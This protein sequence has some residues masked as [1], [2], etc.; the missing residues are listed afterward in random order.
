MAACPACLDTPGALPPA[1]HPRSY[2][3]RQS[4]WY[5]VLGRLMVFEGHRGMDEFVA[6]FKHRAQRLPQQQAAK[7]LASFR[8]YPLASLDNE[9]RNMGRA[10]RRGLQASPRAAHELGAAAVLQQTRALWVSPPASCPWSAPQGWT[11]AAR[12]LI[13]ACCRRTTA[14]CCCSRCLGSSSWRRRPAWTW[15]G[16]RL[17][18]RGA[19]GRGRGGGGAQPAGG[20]EPCPS[21]VE[22]RH[23]SPAV[24]AAGAARQDGA[25]S[26]AAAGC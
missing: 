20:A 24:Q 6:A 15:G 10:G 9:T 23:A 5:Q 22:S 14:A 16:W 1:P 26:G 7:V 11:V 12:V 21:C 13:S 25:P 2:S 17:W 19:R 18:A 8:H 4:I 3:L